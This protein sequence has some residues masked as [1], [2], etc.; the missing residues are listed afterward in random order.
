MTRRELWMLGLCVLVVFFVANAF[1]ARSV[2]KVLRGS[3]AKIAELKNTLADYEMW[4]EDAPREEARV[5]WLD[6]N[7]PRRDGGSLGKL[8]GDLIQTLQDDLYGRKLRIDRQSLQ[9]VVE[10]NHYI[11]VSARLEV[12]GAERDVVEWLTTLQGPDK[13]QVVKDLEIELD[14]RSREPVPQA[15][16]QITIARWFKPDSGELPASAPEPGLPLAESEAASPPPSPEDT[17]DDASNDAGAADEPASARIP[18]EEPDP[19]AP[20][21][22]Q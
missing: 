5:R 12:R 3:D 15:K 16:C 14:T 22:S 9:D 1:A 10:G 19:Q 2:L 8:Q 7:M 20:Q 18:Q 17:D 6:E 11:E 4:L 21:E 13:F